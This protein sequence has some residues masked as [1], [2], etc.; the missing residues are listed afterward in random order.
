MITLYFS[1]TGNSEYIARRFAARMKSPC[2]S[3]EEAV[4]FTSLLAT[5]DTVAVCYPVYGSC[6]PRIMREFAAEHS[7][8]LTEK[9][10]IILCTQMIFSGDGAR[11]F[12]RLLPGCDERVIY[13]EHFHMP[14]NISNFWL[15]PI[16]DEERIRKLHAAEQKLERTC[17]Q[18]QNGIVG[19]RG[20]SAFSALLGKFQNIAW[21]MLEN[22][23]KGSFSV[24]QACNRCGLC[25]R[26]CPVHNLAL[27]EAGVTQKNNCILCYRCVNLCPQKAAAVMLRKRPKR[28]YKGIEQSESAQYQ[29]PT[30]HNA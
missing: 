3:I 27:T 21:P 20:W 11:A 2:H 14:N 24:N 16:R 13:A 26:R 9:K 17:T 22:R 1:G 28:Q 19:R 29:R 10:L 15:F 18:I 7:T 8:V 25:V 12:A 4:D 5:T 6:V 23:K 30:H